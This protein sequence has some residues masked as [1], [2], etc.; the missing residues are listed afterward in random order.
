MTRS[1]FR[2]SVLLENALLGQKTLVS[3]SHLSDLLN[4]WNHLA[5]CKPKQHSQDWILLVGIQCNA[6][7]RIHFHIIFYSVSVLL[8]IYELLAV[9][10]HALPH[11]GICTQPSNSKTQLFYFLTR[12]ALSNSKLIFIQ[13]FTYERRGK[14]PKYDKPYRW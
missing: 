3:I 12:I 14:C 4:R 7:N 13:S 11:E 6:S 5:N 9:S 2:K 1:I 10:M 8:M